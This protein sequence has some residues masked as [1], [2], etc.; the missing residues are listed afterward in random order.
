VLE[1]CAA[2]GMGAF[3]IWWTWPRKRAAPKNGAP[4][5]PS[6]EAAG[7]DAHEGEDKSAK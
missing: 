5:Q 4:G 1:M 2:F 6:A 3:I 7:K